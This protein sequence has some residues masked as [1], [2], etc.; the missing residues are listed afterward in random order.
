LK[1]HIIG[2]RSN[3]TIV[4]DLDDMFLRNLTY[5]VGNGY[6]Y[7]AT[8][9]ASIEDRTITLRA[10]KLEIIPHPLTELYKKAQVQIGANDVVFARFDMNVSSDVQIKGLKVEFTLSGQTLKSY[11]PE[12]RAVTLSG[13]GNKVS[14]EI[15]S[16]FYTVLFDRD[17][18]VFTGVKA[19][20]TYTGI[21]VFTGN[22]KVADDYFT[23]PEL[24]KI[25]F[26][27]GKTVRGYILKGTYGLP[28]GVTITDPL[29]EYA[30]VDGTGANAHLYYAKVCSKTSPDVCYTFDRD[31]M[32]L[33]V[34]D[35]MVAWCKNDVAALTNIRLIDQTNDK[36]LLSTSINCANLQNSEENYASL[37]IDFN[38]S[39]F[40]LSKGQH[41][42]AVVANIPVARDDL[43]GKTIRSKLLHPRYWTYVRD[44]VT[45]KKFNPDDQNEV[46]P[47]SDVVFTP[48]TLSLPYI[49]VGPKAFT[50]PDLVAGATDYVLAKYIV[51]LK[52]IGNIK[53]Y[54]PEFRVYS[55]LDGK[56]LDKEFTKNV[57]LSVDL[58]VNGE[59]VATDSPDSEGLVHFDGAFGD[60]SADDSTKSTAILELRAHITNDTTQLSK[61]KALVT[62]VNYLESDD[63]YGNAYVLSPTRIDPPY[64]KGGTDVKVL[65]IKDYIKKEPITTINE[66]KTID[67][68]LY[69]AIVVPEKNIHVAGKL[70]ITTDATDTEYNYRFMVADGETL[71]KVM[72]I[73]LGA[74]YEDFNVTTIKGVVNTGANA[75][76]SIKLIDNG[77]VVAV[78]YPDV[79]GNFTFD[80]LD[81]TVSAN[82]TKDL[83]VA[84]VV[85]NGKNAKIAGT[86][87]QLDITEVKGVGKVTGK[88]VEDKTKT[89]SNTYVAA[90]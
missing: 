84:V 80:N 11:E 67:P 7:N 48:L 40:D 34:E 29:L 56:T 51:T 68:V 50:R 52:N 21:I 90:V 10:A 14:A 26:Y 19:I 17:T 13:V 37:L 47:G 39:V 15:K 35:T 64:I 4:F 44:L 42:L 87:I 49:Y 79:N 61:V 62:A 16:D 32:N 86:N 77:N 58:Y 66:L 70:A 30:V 72:K 12:I 6:V 69:A 78:A 76:D 18:D 43:D 8:A 85:Q 60:L 22:K 59:K 36:V 65:L 53:L 45:G 82:D 75:V 28:N 57:V 54:S 1:G 27:I 23:G 89:S 33:N 81:L 46:I 38:D 73:S 31:V 9:S 63:N 88:L 5:D 83:E 25:K 3:D 41:K 20:S 24:G 74:N 55:S 71:N 2:G